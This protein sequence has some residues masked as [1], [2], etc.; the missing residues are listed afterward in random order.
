MNC[1][2]DQKKKMSEEEEAAVMLSQNNK[3]AENRVSIPFAS[4]I[5]LFA[6]RQ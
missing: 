2:V 1:S 6:R 4:F 3:K 5:S